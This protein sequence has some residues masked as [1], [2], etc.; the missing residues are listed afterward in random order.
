MSAGAGRAGPPVL[1]VGHGLI[2]C[3][4]RAM[5]LAARIPVVSIGRRPAELPGYQALDLASETGRAAL[6]AAVTELRPACVVLV[7]GPSDVTWIDQNEASAAAVHCGVAAIVARSGAPA[8]LVSTDNVFPGRRG[9]YRPDDPAEPANGY[10]RIKARAESVLLAGRAASVLRV[11]LVYGWA[12]PGQRAT[13]GQRCLDAAAAGRPVAAPTDQA[14]TP[15]HVRDVATVIAA[16]CRS[17]RPFSGVRHLAG[18]AELSR[19]EFARLAYRLAGADEALVRPCLRQDSEWACRPRFSSLECGN[20]A[21]LAGLAAWQP[22]TPAEG[23]AEMLADRPAVRG[24]AAVT[25]ADRPAGRGDAAVET[26]PAA[27]LGLAAGR[28]AGPR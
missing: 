5:L 3:A 17:G 9:G 13:F 21:G 10:G 6:R 1:V 7:H 28:G 25:P 14:F 2:G 15:I 26:H 18:P 23:L 24:D 19:H 11:S 4:V 16:G 12:G 22:M 20:F 27:G 8:V